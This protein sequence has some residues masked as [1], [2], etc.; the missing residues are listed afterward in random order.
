MRMQ[1]TGQVVSSFFFPLFS[2]R[3]LTFRPLDAPF[4]CFCLFL[5]LVVSRPVITLFILCFL[6][7]ASNKIAFIMSIALSFDKELPSR[8]ATLLLS[9][10]Q[11]S[12]RVASGW[13]RMRHTRG[14]FVHSSAY[15]VISII[16][17]KISQRSMYY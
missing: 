1:S 17:I 10:S 7:V 5:L 2:P 11:S 15:F 16:D 6:R 4:L 13:K 14:F 8:K 3:A 9:F 12:R